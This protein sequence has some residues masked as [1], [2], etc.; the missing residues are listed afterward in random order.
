MVLRTV[1]ERPGIKS[2][3]ALDIQ[4]GSKNLNMFCIVFLV[5]LQINQVE[6]LP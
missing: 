1:I 3:Q 6:V 4:N 2:P 5:N